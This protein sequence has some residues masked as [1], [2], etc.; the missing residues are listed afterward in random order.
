MNESYLPFRN[1]GLFLSYKKNC[2]LQ[3]HKG[4]QIQF[5]LEK[6]NT[7]KSKSLHTEV[8]REIQKSQ[9]F[10][11]AFME[12]HRFTQIQRA[13]S[14]L[15]SNLDCSESPPPSGRNNHEALE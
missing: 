11:S 2:I 1:L 5:P 8:F 6:K 3:D 12:N 14:K 7:P 10:Y 9:M 13:R 15:R 4:L